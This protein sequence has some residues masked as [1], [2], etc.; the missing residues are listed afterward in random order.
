M[1]SAGANTI[2]FATSGSKVLEL[3]PDG[4]IDVANG[5][6]HGGGRFAW[7]PDQFSLGVGY[8]ALGT[9][10][11]AG[12]N[13]AIG[14][15]ALGALSVGQDNTAVGTFAMGSSSAGYDNVA[16]G[17]RALQASITGSSNTAVGSGSLLS[18]TGSYNT[19]VGAGSGLGIGN[20]SNNVAF[21]FESLTGAAGDHNAAIGDYAG[22]NLTGSFNTLVG[23]GAGY[24]LTADSNN[25][26]IANTGIAGDS[27]VMRI[28]DA[29]HQTKTFVAGIRGV[30][31]GGSAVAVVIDGNGQLGTVS[32]S[33]RYKEDIQD[34]GGASD[35]LMRLRPVTYRYKQPM[36][37]GSKPR[38]FGLIAEEVDEV[39]PELVARNKN[40]Q[41]E[42]VQYY[43][44]DAMLLNELQKQRRII[45]A[46]ESRLAALEAQ[47]SAQKP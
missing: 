17:Y 10:N 42:T 41:I 26:D 19:A 7:M 2:D 40:G 47:I 33:R 38:E 43:K 36:A 6:R 34:M 3:R 32:S 20:G 16:L 27:G 29:S 1:Y 45:K 12:Y 23:S 14:G 8:G 5:L 15:S 44:L 22:T 39:Y 13:T 28:G 46:L 9:G 4:D 30:T 24:N 21:G 25:V 11:L 31:T 35:G 37:D 18:S